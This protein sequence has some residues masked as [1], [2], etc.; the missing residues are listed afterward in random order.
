[1]AAELPLWFGQARGTDLSA[2]IDLDADDS[3]DRGGGRDVAAG[4]LGFIVPLAIVVSSMG[5]GQLPIAAM[6]IL[7]LVGLAWLG[8]GLAACLVAFS[9]EETPPWAEA[10]ITIL[11]G[12]GHIII[13]AAAIATVVAVLLF[14]IVLVMG[15]ASSDSR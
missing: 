3:E 7:G 1:M 14:F 15:L 2:L 4:V 12:L 9:E 11:V 10:F 5:S 6:V 8:A 13:I